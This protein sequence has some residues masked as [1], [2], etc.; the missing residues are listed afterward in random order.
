MKNLRLSLSLFFL[1][2]ALLFAQ[3]NLGHH[4]HD[5]FFLSISPG[6]AFG[7]SKADLGG[8]AGSWDNIT[9]SGPGGMLD[10]KIGG[11]IKENFILSFDVIGRNVRGPDMETVGGTTELDKDVVLSDGTL[12]LGLTYYIMP[13]NVFLSGTLGVGRFVLTNPT[14]DT[15]DDETIETNPGLSLH[16]KIGKEWWVS[17]NWGLGVAAG[18]GYLGAERDENS[19]SDFNGDYSSHKVYILFNTTF[20]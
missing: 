2:P 5:G 10:F 4:R 8:N 6:V 11:A 1:A 13:A 18:Y 9:Y 7:S 12:G 16:A 14:E 17:D 3:P 20:N 19:D 15:E